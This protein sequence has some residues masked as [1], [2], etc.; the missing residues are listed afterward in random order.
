L[1]DEYL[2]K[3]TGRK[4]QTYRITYRSMDRPLSKEEVNVIHK[5]IESYLVDKFGMDIR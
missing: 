4:S 5:K 1:T 3:K 2:N